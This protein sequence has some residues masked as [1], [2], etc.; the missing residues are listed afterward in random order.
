[1]KLTI[2]A[3]EY[4]GGLPFLLC[5][6]NQNTK[7]VKG[8]DPKGCIMKISVK[9]RVFQLVRKP[10]I[11]FTVYGF[12]SGR[13][14]ALSIRA[15]ASLMSCKSNQSRSLCSMKIPTLSE[16]IQ[17]GLAVPG[18]SGRKKYAKMAMGKDMTPL[19][20][21]DRERLVQFKITS[22]IGVYQT[23]ISIPLDPHVH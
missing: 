10:V 13:R 9:R 19:I 2:C 22:V 7:A 20:T 5:A 14:P 3:T 16:K 18:V 21:R 15:R 1:M 4:T 8:C 11:A 12:P 6:F 17:L 23:A